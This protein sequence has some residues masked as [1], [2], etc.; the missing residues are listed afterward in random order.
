MKFLALLRGINV[1]GKNIISKEELRQLFLDLGFENIRTHIQSGNILFRSNKKSSKILA[2]NIEEELSARFSYAARAVVLSYDQYKSAVE[3]A[4]GNWGKDNKQKHNALFLL[5]NS[6]PTKVS[7]ELPSQKP[8]IEA[9]ALGENV[10][11]WSV[12]KEHLTKTSY[13]KLAKLQVYQE[14]TIRNHNTVLKLLQL[15]D[16]I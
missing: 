16:E 1:G 11:F 12:S 13:M 15:F 3:S 5:G 7:T 4:P 9:I 2:K 8:G 14:V 10:I 6:I